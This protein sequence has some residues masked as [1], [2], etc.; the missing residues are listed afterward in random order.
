VTPPERT[1]A[2]QRAV[3]AAIDTGRVPSFEA[4]GVGA[5]DALLHCADAVGRRVARER[6]GA[7]ARLRPGT[8]EAAARAL[9]LAVRTVELDVGRH[10]WRD[11]T[12]P[13]AARRLDGSWVALVPGPHGLVRIA[14]DGSERRMSDAEAADHGPTAWALVPTFADDIGR[15][16]DAARL[17]WPAGTGRDLATLCGIGL[18]SMAISTLVPIL[19]GQ[20]V[21]QLVP[22]GEV[23]R[24]VVL[25]AVL[26][27]AA[28]LSALTL[29]ASSIVAQRFTTRS[30]LR[31]TAAAYER[32][33]RLRTS[34][35][36]AHQPGELAERIAGVETFRAGVAGATP[37][38]V[39]AVATIVA[40]VLVLAG[41]SSVLALA[42]LVMS[43]LTLGGGA[44][45]LP[46]LLRDARSY[47]ASSIE[48][49]GLGFS[50]LGG[51]AKIRSA[52]AE[53]RMLDRWLFRFA[54]QQRASRQLNIRTMLLGLIA[55]VPASL[56]PIV[57]V[58]GEVSGAATM[59]IGEFTTATS[60]AAQA[61][62]AVAGLL[63]VAATLV[64]L[65]PIVAALRPILDATPEP[66]G[67][68]A[69][70]PGELT[71]DVR[72]DGVTFG[73]DPEVPVLIDVSLLVPAGSMTAIV[74]AS[75]S[76][77][78]S[79]VKLLLGLEI[80]QTGTVLYDGTALSSLDRTA[81]LAQMGI[82]PQDAALVPGSILENIL[83]A[84]PELDEEAAWRAAERAQV[85]EDIRAMPMG[86]QTV[87]S[88]GASTFSGGQRQ[89][90]MIA[91]ALVREPRIL[92]L[93]EATSALDNPTQ[94][95]VAAAIA[96]VGATRIVVAH[97][98]ST[99]RHADQI[100]VVDAGRIVEVGT[101]DELVAG[102]GVFA[103]LAAR[104]VT[105]SEIDAWK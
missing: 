72:L 60:A 55:T 37:A 18:V 49:S 83:V 86:M 80:P 6:I 88:D 3:R 12:E 43:L 35:H 24:I 61:A 94:E 4:T 31:V 17:A 70:D 95:R 93:D 30:S 38:V 9:G 8:A 68:A 47:T 48:L 75:G 89:R 25:T 69:S 20:I 67:S 23:G 15:A 73:Y 14:P 40:S 34:F 19:S 64:S 66:R 100:V 28:A 78:S 45:L 7:A 76:G 32:V 77:K 21:G 11:S 104:Q 51:I 97:R 22:T 63:P 52:G 39:S 99:I 57:L 91:R 50:M 62:G 102:A 1:S 82:V 74:G 92:V 5:V 10:W 56:V 58:L 101:H 36:R 87:V 53:Q 79:I 33:F 90:L 71:G 2:A 26:V 16:R 103:R 42:V 65:A 105:G 27:L 81:V 85:A 98:L 54:H 29:S 96:G 41:V 44:L 46:R 13:F 59:P 84:A